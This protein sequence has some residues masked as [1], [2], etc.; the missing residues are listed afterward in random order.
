[1]D[2][3]TP[4]ISGEAPS[5]LRPSQGNHR[6]RIRLRHMLGLLLTFS[7]GVLC[8]IVVGRIAVFQIAADYHERRPTK[9]NWVCFPLK[10]DA[11]MAENVRYWFRGTAFGHKDIYK[12]LQSAGRSVRS[13]YPGS[14][15]VYRDVSYPC[16]GKMGAH[17]SH[18][19]GHD[20]DI[21]YFSCSSNGKKRYTRQSWFYRGPKIRHTPDTQKNARIR[22]DPERNWAFVAALREN[23][24]AQVQKIL[25]EPHIREWLLDEAKHK[26]ASAD[27]IDWARSVLRYAGDGAGAHDDHMHIRFITH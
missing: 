6:A 20:V 25:V 24:H 18:R 16:G 10:D 14:Y 3:N 23:S 2:K 13:K 4:K 9:E 15:V 27:L 12:A 5:T 11:I 21:L 17:K 26:Q 1:M 7:L 8:T 22:F 19:D